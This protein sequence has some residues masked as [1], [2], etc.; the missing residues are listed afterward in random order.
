MA[1][2]GGG[3][4]ASELV[5]AQQGLG[6]RMQIA[7]IYFDLPTIYLNIIIIGLFGFMMDR[8]LL[9]SENRLIGWQERN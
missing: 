5:A 7:G 1:P 4:V 9:L 2:G 6:Y 3:F 8:L